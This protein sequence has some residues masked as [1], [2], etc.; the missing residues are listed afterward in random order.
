MRSPRW[1]ATLLKHPIGTTHFVMENFPTAIFKL[2][3]R[4]NSSDKMVR[5]IRFDYNG[6]PI[7]HAISEVDM[8]KSAPSVV[9]LLQETNLPIGEVVR[10]FNVRRTRLRST[11]RS[12][13]FHFVGDL[14]AR[15]LER[16]Y[17]ARQSH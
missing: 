7:V 15:V 6:K 4:R 13:E 2:E 12:R 17:V 3:S 10:R 5:H 1:F 16:F 8:K 14:H 11:T 9:R